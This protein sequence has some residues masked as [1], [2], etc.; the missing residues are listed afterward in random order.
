MYRAPTSVASFVLTDSMIEEMSNAY[1][2]RI[3]DVNWPSNRSGN[4]NLLLDTDQGKVV[5]SR[6]EE[7][8]LEEVAN[9]TSLLVWL[10]SHRF[11][12]TTLLALANGDHIF[13]LAGKPAFIRNYIPGSITRQ[14]TPSMAF[15]LG[16]EVARLHAT[17]VPSFLPN[18]LYFEHSRF[19]SVLKAGIDRH[20]ERWV[21]QKRK[22]SLDLQIDSVPAGLVHADLFWDNVLFQEEELIA[23]IDFELACNYALVFDLSMALVGMFANGRNLNYDLARRF[24]KGYQTRRP[25][26]CEEIQLI[27]ALCEYSAALVA[28]WRYWRYRLST[29]RHE[30]RF[31][32]QL[33]FR[34]ATN[35]QRLG[36]NFILDSLFEAL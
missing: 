23:V 25:L 1:G 4:V 21:Q 12:T 14:L 5:L 30:A 27:P 22:E 20:F 33:M 10:E 6:I 34:L 2:F 13:Q 29:I 3:H 31:S 8:S 7:Q 18:T 28:S 35:L 17:P 11:R 24:L 15:A 9:M 19:S 36:P 16:K 26:S 32:Y